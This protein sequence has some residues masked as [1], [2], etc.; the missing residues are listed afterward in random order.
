[1]NE[2]AFWEDLKS[3]KFA[4][5]VREVAQGETIS[6]ARELFHILKPLYAR[7]SDVEAMWVLFLNGQNHIL[8]ME[9]MFTG[10]INRASVYPREL[11]KRILKHQASA[12]ILAHNHPSGTTKPSDDDHQLTR[13]VIWAATCIDVLVHDHIIIAAS[14]YHSMADEGTISRIKTEIDRFSMK[15]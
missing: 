12:V 9:R 8:A 5:L 14:G 3:G 2:K 4:S 11:I 1:M 10:S 15:C 13:K 6:S 7:E